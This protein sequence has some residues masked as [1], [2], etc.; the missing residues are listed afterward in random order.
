LIDPQRPTSFE[1]FFFRDPDGYVFEV[2]AAERSPEAT[3]PADRHQ[4]SP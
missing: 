3:A 1:R 4:E 2:V